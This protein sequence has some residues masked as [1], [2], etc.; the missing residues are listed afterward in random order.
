MTGKVGSNEQ[1]IIL[2]QLLKHTPEERPTSQELL[3]S[4]YVPPKIEL[5]D[6]ENNISDTTCSNGDNRNNHKKENHYNNRDK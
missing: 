5:D 4:H 1:T 6:D 2:K 3:Q